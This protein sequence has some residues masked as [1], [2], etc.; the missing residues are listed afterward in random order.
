MHKVLDLD[1]LYLLI[2]SEKIK[3]WNNIGDKSYKE[4]KEAFQSELENFDY[5][6]HTEPR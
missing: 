3:S 4:I 1:N 2:A 6:R 5:A